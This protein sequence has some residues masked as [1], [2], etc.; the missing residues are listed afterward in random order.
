MNAKSPVLEQY[1]RDL[2]PVALRIFIFL[3]VVF[4]CSH[5]LLLPKPVALPMTLLSVSAVVIGLIIQAQINH[6]LADVG[7]GSAGFLP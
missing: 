5:Y 3:Y 1:G 4:S 2:L 7:A 6:L